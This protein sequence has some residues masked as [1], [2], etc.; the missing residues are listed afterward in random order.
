MPT[1]QDPLLAPVALRMSQTT[2]ADP[3]TT[4]GSGA[5]EATRLW[6]YWTGRQMC[7]ELAQKLEQEAPLHGKLPSFSD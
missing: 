1:I 5:S 4:T 2:A 6:I 3:A 7:P